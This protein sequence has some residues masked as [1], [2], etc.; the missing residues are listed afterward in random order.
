MSNTKKIYKKIVCLLTAVVLLVGGIVGKN[1]YDIMAD[2][3]F[4]Q[5]LKSFPESYRPYIQALH[6]KH[7]NWT[8]EA[9][10][11][12]L[13]WNEVLKNEALLKENLFRQQDTVCH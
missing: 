6:D 5:T 10:N 7:P 11:T 2:T 13:D 4:E 1:I 9:F 8:F 12:G 3:S